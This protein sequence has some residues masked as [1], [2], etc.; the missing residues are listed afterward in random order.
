MPLTVVLTESPAWQI[1]YADSDWIVAT[2]HGRLTF[3][4]P[5]SASGA[6]GRSAGPSVVVL[7]PAPRPSL[8][9]SCRDVDRTTGRA[10]RAGCASS[11]VLSPVR[12]VGFESRPAAT[13]L[14][15]LRRLLPKQRD[16][17]G[18][19]RPPAEARHVAHVDSL[20]EHELQDGVTEERSRCRNRH[21]ADAGD[22]AHLAVL[23]TPGGVAAARR[24]ARARR[25]GGGARAPRAP[26]RRR[27]RRAPLGSAACTHTHTHT[28][29]AGTE[30]RPLAA[31]AHG[32]GGAAWPARRR[33]ASLRSRLARRRARHA[34]PR[35]AAPAAA[36]A[37][38]RTCA[39]TH[40]HAH[41]PAAPASASARSP[42]PTTTTTPPRLASPT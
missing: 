28:H 3:T 38:P 1:R 21:R 22:L 33:R 36:L 18:R 13:V 41:R 24:R 16:L 26:R 30:G 25:G 14:D 20:R 42:G 19:S 29:T 34:S 17:L 27:R 40:T 8:A 7:F 5:A 15:G 32:G 9:S 10:R 4:A 2:R 39:H 35:S 6:S 31:P 12:M 37:R 11:R 23:G